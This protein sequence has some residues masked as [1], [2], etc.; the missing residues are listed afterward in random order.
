MD[1]RDHSICDADHSPAW[2]AWML[3]LRGEKNATK[4]SR[5]HSRP[6]HSLFDRGDARATLHR[7]EELVLKILFH[8][9]CAV[10]LALAGRAEAQ[11]WPAR[12]LTMVV[13][14][15]AGGPADVLGRILALHLGEVAGKQVVVENITGAGGMT[16]SL[17]V[18]QG[19]PDGHLFVLG[20]I[21]THAL[22]QT[23]YKKPLYNAAADFAPVA[24]VADV[25]LVLIARKDFPAD[26]LQGFIAYA[27]SNHSKMQYGS[28]GTGTSAHIGCVLLNQAI[29]VDVTHIP[30]RGGGPAMADL[31]A[32]RV[33]YV[34]NIAS[35]AVPAIEANSVKAV[36]TLSRE[37]TPVLPDLG[38]AHEQ[39]L[40]DFDAYTW[41]AVFL[42]KGT[43]PEVVGKLNAALVQVMNRPAFVERLQKVGLMVVAPERRSPD[44]L[45]QF[46]AGEIEKW[47]API[48][49]SGAREE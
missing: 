46:V 42:P 29:G 3:F 47:A 20:S 45:R 28:G 1:V 10:L 8:L 4:R 14:F 7:S 15:A 30:Y 37:R 11:D 40:R 32:G 23:L 44:Y 36:A 2:I 48:K 12:P 19:E 18:S 33:D 16:G 41:N 39:G 35:T 17:R 22:N 21:G 31:M 38:T 24:L 25:P 5:P 6:S 27:K 26:D 43:S 49:S 13:P 34:C 9:A